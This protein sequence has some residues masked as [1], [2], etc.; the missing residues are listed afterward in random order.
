MPAAR[1]RRQRAVRTTDPKPAPEELAT[2]QAFVNTG[3]PEKTAD[4]LASPRELGRWLASHGLLK[5]G[6]ELSEDERRRA[7]EVRVGLRAL[8]AAHRGG[9]V[10]TAA[11]ECLEPA[12]GSARLDLRFDDG[13]VPAGFGPAAGSIDDA[14]GELLAFVATGRLAG[15]WPLLKLCAR[16]GCGRAFYD[17]SQSRTSKWC[18]ARCGDRVRAAAYRRTDWHKSVFKR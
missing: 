1:R 2:V 14:L 18:N 15:H 6:I 7:V 8:L 13:G 12:A 9:K 4:E 16:D 11:V 3:R 10:D 5:A 17:G